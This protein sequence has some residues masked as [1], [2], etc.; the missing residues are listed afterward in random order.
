MNDYTCMNVHESFYVYMVYVLTL[1]FNN[2]ISIYLFGCTGS[3]LWYAGSLIFIVVCRI[4]FPDQGWNL[5]PMHW[6]C[7]VLP[8]G[9]P[10]KSP[11][12]HSSGV[13]R[14]LGCFQL[15]AIVDDGAATFQQRDLLFCSP[16]RVKP[17]EKGTQER[18]PGP[19]QGFKR[20][21]LDPPPLPV[22]FAPSSARP[23]TMRFQVFIIKQSLSHREQ[24]TFHSTYTTHIH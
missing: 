11:C 9:P 12:V 18:Q 13:G 7:E 1:F 20:P 14:H 6:K 3:Q 21:V 10:G 19:S 5:D 22:L 4:Q 16:R 24:D 17:Q 8:T 2:F 15:G 23:Q